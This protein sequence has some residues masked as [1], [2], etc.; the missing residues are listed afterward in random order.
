MAEISQAAPE[1]REGIAG[2]GHGMRAMDQATPQHSAPVE[3]AAAAAP[4]LPG[5]IQSAHGKSPMRRK[6]RPRP[7]GGFRCKGPLGER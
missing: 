7:Y 3:Q 5:V 6:R 2:V 1:Q 4:A